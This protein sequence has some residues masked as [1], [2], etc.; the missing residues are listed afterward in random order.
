M[1]IELL[2][3]CKVIEWIQNYW[4]NIKF[5]NEYGIIESKLTN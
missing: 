3:K 5:L 4:I 2:N 1:N